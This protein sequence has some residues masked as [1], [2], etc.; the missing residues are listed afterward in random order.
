MPWSI[1]FIYSLLRTTQ[2]LADSVQ[3]SDREAFY[4]TLGAL[5]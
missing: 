1:V 4:P 2:V 5:L 3:Y